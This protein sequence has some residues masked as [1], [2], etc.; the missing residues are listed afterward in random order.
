MTTLLRFWSAA[1]VMAL[2]IHL[3]GFPLLDADE[4]RNAEVARE[5][6]ETNDYVMPRLN[7]L[8]YVDKPIV[9]FAAEAA[10]MEV[11]GPTE[12]AARLPAYL[13]TIATAAVLFFFARRQWGGDAPWI[14]VIVFLA[15]PLTLAFARTVIFDSA[16]TFFV[17]VALI[18]FYLAIEEREK[19]WSILAWAAVGASM[20][21]K[22]P[23]VFIL[24]LFV[25]IPYAVWRSRVEGRGEGSPSSGAARHLLPARGEKGLGVVFPVLGLLAFIAI[26]APW[27]WGVTRV[28]P[29]FLRYV[30]VTETAERMATTALKRTGPPWYFVP[31]LI[32]GA[33]PWSLVALFSWKS[34]KRRE[35]LYLG[36]WIAIPFIFFSLNQSKRPQYILPLMPA[37]ALILA[38]IWQEARTRGAAIVLTAFGALLLAAPLFLHRAKMKPEI[39]AVADETAIALGIAFAAG[40]IAALWAK[41]RELVLVA[42]SLPAIALPP[43]TQPMMRALGERRSTKSFVAELRPHLGPR[44]QVV[45]V[46]AFTGSLAFY[47]Q[48][49]IVLVSEDASELTSNYLIRRYDRYTSD[50]ASPL[51]RLEYFEQSLGTCCPVYILRNNDARRRAL[52]ESR[53]WRLVADGAHHV[54]YAR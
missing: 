45:G 54:A 41:R 7:G 19:K 39:A 12:L 4:G 23:V 1:A 51:K 27:V 46:E 16:L 18:A 3:G 31:Y 21:T 5:M 36:L 53:G 17:V 14:A 48:R 33:L 37:L 25:A 26:I 43:A 49:P 50:P 28:V 34:L 29:D 44:T 22:G 20:I 13:F 35:L 9:Y 38:R 42:L 30:L 40:G 52:L 47:L 8:P 6:A 15:T 11:L 2:A 24:V 10:A 32:G